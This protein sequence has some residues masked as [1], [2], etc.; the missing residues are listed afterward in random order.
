MTYGHSVNIIAATID[1][2]FRTFEHPKNWE[3]EFQ[4]LREKG[5][6][7]FSYGARI[8]LMPFGS[9]EIFEGQARFSQI[10]YLSY[11]GG[12]R[13]EWDDYRSLG[14]LGPEYT[15]AFEHFLHFVE[16][17]WP[18][19]VDHPLVG[20]FL[21][22]CDL[23]I[24]PGRG[25]PFPIAP[26]FSTFV[27]DVSPAMRFAVYCRLVALRHPSLKNAIRAHTRE[28]YE[29]T[30]S[31][32]CDDLDDPSPLRIAQTF[33]DWFARGG[34]FSGLRQEYELYRFLQ[35]NFVIRHLFAHFLAFQ[36]D[37]FR[38]PEFFCWPGAWLA[39]SNLTRRDHDLFERHGAPFVD[40]ED[41][42]AIFA[43]R[44]PGRT[45]A[46]LQ[47]TFDAFYQ[48]AVVFDLTNQWISAPGP[49]SYDISWLV[50]RA[51]QQEMK[52]Y[53]RRQFQGA[54]GLDLDSVEIVA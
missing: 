35:P 37:K 39:G 26:K 30:V 52:Q 43:R 49:F 12:H 38:R 44:Q 40:K 34:P 50:P 29:T 33:S 25:F 27:N 19:R 3:P 10:Q 11:A 48:N 14:M 53:L 32:L 2:D 36:E 51:T 8:E 7:G 16:A 45:E 22:I 54:F 24:N 20:L 9:R 6:P 1:R 17:P 46:A 28:E 18:G 23:S 4:A 13:F 41:D 47:E 15:S 5:A 31:T 21:L 42:D